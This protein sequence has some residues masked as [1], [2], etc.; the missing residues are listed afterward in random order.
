MKIAGRTSTVTTPGA[1]R[2]G[3]TLIEIMVVVAI[4]AIVL[5]MGVPLVYRLSHKEPLRKA[6]ADL[7]EL[8]SN[9]RAQAILRSA[10]TEV[11]FRPHE[12]TA[13]IGGGSAPAPRET[14]RGDE[15]PAE[16]RIPGGTGPTA[17]TSVHLPESVR[18]LLLA[19]DQM[20]RMDQETVRV[21]F[22]PNGTCDEMFMIYEGDGQQRG[23][24][25]EVTTGLASTLD[26][27]DLQEY[28]NR[29]Q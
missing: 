9:A 16:T 3:F 20:D 18:I 28:R 12:G 10:A 29:A 8:F 24:T 1:R 11:V 5:T 21:R 25:L 23:I 13:T 19:I 6:T 22:Y 26:E 2:R 14:P 17:T 15:M 7:V 27:Q 4:M